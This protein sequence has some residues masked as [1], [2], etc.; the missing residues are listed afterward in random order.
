VG[1]SLLYIIFLYSIFFIY[2]STQESRSFN[3]SILFLL[4]ILSFFSFLTRLFQNN[5]TLFFYI[6]LFVFFSIFLQFN[7]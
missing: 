2:F 1:N 6:G 5:S 7:F 4:V 3:Y